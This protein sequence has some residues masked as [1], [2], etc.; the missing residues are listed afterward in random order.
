M[1]PID[2]SVRIDSLTLP[3]SAAGI[4][5]DELLRRVELELERLLEHQPLPLPPADG[6]RIDAS[7]GPVLAATA[8]LPASI[9]R[10]IA[11]RIHSSIQ[12]GAART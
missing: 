6:L 2:V 4:D 8:A 1:D 3:P 10:A 5:R 11:R 9:A 7:G 12:R